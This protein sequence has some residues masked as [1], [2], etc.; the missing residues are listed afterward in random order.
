MSVSKVRVCHHKLSWMHKSIVHS[1][2][3]SPILPYIQPY[4]TLLKSTLPYLSDMPTRH[5][6]SA[7]EVLR[8]E[9]IEHGHHMG[10]S[11]AY[12]SDDDDDDDDGGIT[13]NQS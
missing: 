12:A 1:T 11:I 6:Q 13:L 9:S 8:H 5:I 4:P 7:D 10:D 3:L 2:F